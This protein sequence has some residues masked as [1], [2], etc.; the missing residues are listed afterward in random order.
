MINKHP[1][2][3]RSPENSF[4]PRAPNVR[5]VAAALSNAELNGATHAA[6]LV[7]PDPAVLKRLPFGDTL[8]ARMRRVDYKLADAKTFVTDLPNPRGTRLALA[9]LAP[10]TTA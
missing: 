10:D 1:R 8:A 5:R 3:S 6:L 4:D 9:P 2:K 7:T